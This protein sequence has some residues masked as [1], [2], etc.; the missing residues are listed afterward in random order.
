[1]HIAF[2]GGGVSRVILSDNLTE[3]R[4][5]S[6]SGSVNYDKATENF[7][8]GFTLEGFYTKLND[9]F[10]LQ[11]VGQDEFGNV[12]EKRNGSGAAVQGGTVELRG[13]IN[14]KM[15]LE[16]GFTLQTSLYDEA[17]EYI[18]GVDPRREFLRTPN[19]YGYLTYS[20]TPGDRFNASLSGV[21]TGPMELVHYAGAPEQSVDEYVTSGSFFEFGLKLGYTFNLNVLDS[22]LEIFGGVK[23]FTNAYQ[24]DFDTGKNRDS[25]YIYGPAMP[26]T[27]YIG[28]RLYSF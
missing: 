12:Y 10:Y 14:K 7:I 16:A 8:V 26:R 3:E 24:N 21:Y 9:A 2:A 20:L 1:M 25:G 11:P 22:G 15:Q 28:L 23:N 17:V 5:H 13:N 6:L 4:S 27:F 19:H 18:E